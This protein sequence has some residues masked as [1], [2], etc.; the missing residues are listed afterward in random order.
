MYNENSPDQTVY[1]EGHSF[2]HGVLR[3]EVAK[4]WNEIVDSMNRCFYYF[5]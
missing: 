3:T 2:L 5:L 4:K 1:K